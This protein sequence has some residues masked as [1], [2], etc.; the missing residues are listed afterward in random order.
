[1]DIVEQIQ[2]QLK[3]LPPEKQVEVLNFTTQL[4]SA[5]SKQRSLRQHPA[6]GLWRKRNIDAL[7]YQKD[8]RAE[9]DRS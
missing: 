7:Q 4:I 6:F 9:W 2:E 1:M 5:P 3:K 8:L